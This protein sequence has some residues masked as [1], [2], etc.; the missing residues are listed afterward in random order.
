MFVSG[1]DYADVRD[2]VALFSRRQCCR[3]GASSL[4]HGRLLAVLL[5]LAPGERRQVQ[6][7]VPHDREDKRSRF[8]G[9][10][11]QVKWYEQHTPSREIGWPYSDAGGRPARS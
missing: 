1:L 8:H 10:R 7:R 3:H 9:L 4:T 5:G 6:V 11:A 2:V